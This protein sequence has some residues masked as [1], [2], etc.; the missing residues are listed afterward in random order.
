MHCPCVKE[1]N[2]I[3]MVDCSSVYLPH[4]PAEPYCRVRAITKLSEHFVVRAKTLPDANG[5]ELIMI[6][7]WQGFL[8]KGLASLYLCSVYCSVDTCQAT[9]QRLS[10]C[11]KTNLGDRP[12]HL[13]E[14]VLV[15]Q[16]S[17]CGHQGGTACRSFVR[18]CRPIIDTHFWHSV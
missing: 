10:D 8:F 6:I 9:C 11:L 13:D 14:D 16:A 3:I 5:I 17:V 1:V 12:E 4:I 15:S 18:A 7:M 2:K